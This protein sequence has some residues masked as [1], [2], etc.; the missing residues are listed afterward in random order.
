ME[1]AF[2]EKMAITR[3]DFFKGAL[4]T[5]GALGASPLLGLEAVAAAQI[6]HAPSGSD[7]HAAS[8]SLGVHEHWNNAAEKLYSRNLGKLKG[9]S[10]RV[11]ENCRG[12]P[13]EAPQQI[14]FSR[15]PSTH[16]T[17]FRNHRQT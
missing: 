8:D 14:I 11:V 1:N 13:N 17:V 5:A 3:R 6:G 10:L 7:Y 9:L 15:K 16:S 12:A 4:M 2:G